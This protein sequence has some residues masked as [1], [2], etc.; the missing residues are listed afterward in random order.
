[1]VEEDEREETG[2]RAVLNYG[3]TFAHAF[4]A[5]AGYG[6]SLARRGGGGRHGRRVAPGRAAGLGR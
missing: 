1:M 2:L 6:A 3:H 4:E 5:V